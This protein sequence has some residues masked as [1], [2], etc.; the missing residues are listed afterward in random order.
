[1]IA[2]LFLIPILLCILWFAYL[3]SRGYSIKQGQQGFIYILTF[4]AGLLG[5]MTLML[6]LTNTNT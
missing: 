1:M 6:W 4:S 5:V 2:R 3:R